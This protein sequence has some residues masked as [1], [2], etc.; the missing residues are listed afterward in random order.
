MACLSCGLSDRSSGF[1][2][3]NWD[4]RTLGLRPHADHRG[5]L[6]ER[7]LARLDDARAS[8]PRDSSAALV[9]KIH[10]ARPTDPC[11][12]RETTPR[13]IACASRGLSSPLSDSTLSSWRWSVC[14]SNRARTLGRFRR[15]RTA[16]GGLSGRRRLEPVTFF[17]VGDR[18]PPFLRTKIVRWSTIHAIGANRPGSPPYWSSAHV[19]RASSAQFRQAL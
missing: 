19:P 3:N 18:T 15:R 13:G 10:S 2:S 6:T 17:A 4:R 1:A 8:P 12:K 5:G 11:A 16:R 7:P 9:V 14:G